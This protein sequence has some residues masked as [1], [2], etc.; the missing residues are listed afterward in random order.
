[1]RPWPRP[2]RRRRRRV[3]EVGS[4]H[5]RGGGHDHVRE[6][7]AQK[8]GGG[9]PLHLARQSGDPRKTAPIRYAPGG[10]RSA[11]R[12]RSA[13]PARLGPMIEL[14][15]GGDGGLRTLLDGLLDLDSSLRAARLEGVAREQAALAA[16]HAAADRRCRTCRAG[17][18]PVPGRA[19]G[20]D[21]PPSSRASTLAGKRVG[22][23]VL[24]A[25]LG[26]GGTGAVWRARRVDGRFDG[27][28]AVKLLHLSLIGHIGQLRIRA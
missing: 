2:S 1:M 5:E 20:P 16:D 21:R 3:G 12:P 9:P 10:R 25:P 18:I 24:G 4:A 13:R 22:P 17:A 23:A 11:R 27:A 28:V 6:W 19:L 8:R 26:Q 15:A 14:D 7:R